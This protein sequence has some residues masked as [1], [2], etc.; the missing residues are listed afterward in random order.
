MGESP[1][2]VL[3]K[4]F[5]QLAAPSHV[6]LGLIVLGVLLWRTRW[7]RL[8]YALAVAGI[9]LLIAIVFLPVPN[10]SLESLEDRFPLPRNLPDHVDGIIVLG[11]AL[12]PI[13]TATRGIPSLN[14]AAER[15][16]S[17]V[18]LARL[19]P[20]ATKIFTGGNG[21]LETSKLSEAAV[22]RQLFTELGLDTQ[23]IFYEDKSRNTYENVLFSKQ[24]AHVAPA[25]TWILVTSAQHMPR[26]VGIFR[27]LDWPVIAYPVAYKSDGDF[28]G[29]VG[30]ALNAV[31]DAAHEWI[32]LI[33]Y[34][35]LGR[36]DAL[37]P[38]PQSSAGS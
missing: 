17:F 18:K 37:L 13:E 10:L 5:W 31:D 34:R 15:M 27:K 2:F 21:T 28:F 25:Q 14:E 23:Q 7:T 24:L 26:S 9:G 36:T 11:G 32:G 33:A 22:A 38:L 30:G 35:L 3:S 1:L 29:D 19:Y 20:N 6:V 4:I 12:N 16:T 8:A